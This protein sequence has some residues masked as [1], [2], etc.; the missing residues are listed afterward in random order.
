MV[1]NLVGALLEVAE[2]EENEL[3][4]VGALKGLA[5]GFAQRSGIKVSLQIDEKFSRRPSEV[6]ISI[7]RIIQ[8]SLTNI[9]RHSGSSIAKIRVQQCS[10]CVQIEIE[11][12][13]RGMLLKKDSNL[14]VGLRGMRE[15]ATQLRGTLEINSNGEGTTVIARLPVSTE[16]NIGATESRFD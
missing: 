3:G 13:G 7:Y 6:G 9:H 11:D 8:E 5:D 10:G 15:R 1:R 2:A 4:L 12:A 16:P 14:G